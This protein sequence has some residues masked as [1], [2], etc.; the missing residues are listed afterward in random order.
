MLRQTFLG[1]E[2]AYDQYLCAELILVIN[3]DNN[4]TTQRIRGTSMQVNAPALC[5]SGQTLRVTGR[6]F[7]T[8]ALLFTIAADLCYLVIMACHSSSNLSL[9]LLFVCH[10]VYS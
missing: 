1:V 7:G 9:I 3:R 4:E 10:C 5:W 8:R 2:R 6:P